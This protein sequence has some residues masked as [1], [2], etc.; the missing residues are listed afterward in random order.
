V[1]LIATDLIPGQK[2]TT[3]SYYDGWAATLKPKGGATYSIATLQEVRDARADVAWVPDEFGD[4]TLNNGYIAVLQ[5]ECASVCVSQFGSKGD[6]TTDDTPPIQ[7]AIDSDASVINFIEDESYLLDPIYVKDNNKELN[8]NRCS[9]ISASPVGLT[10]W[11]LINVIKTASPDLYKRPSQ[12]VPILNVVV[13]NFFIDYSLAPTIA[14]TNFNMIQINLGYNCKITNC[15]LLSNFIDSVDVTRGSAISLRGQCESCVIEYNYV[16]TM[17]NHGINHVNRY[18]TGDFTEA[19]GEFGTATYATQSEFS[20]HLVPASTTYADNRVYNVSKV[21]F[22]VHSYQGISTLK[23]NKVLNCGAFFKNQVGASLA[24]GNYCKNVGGS[25]E[26]GYLFWTGWYNVFSEGAD[27]PD[28]LT[29]VI[30]NEFVNSID[31]FNLSHPTLIHNNDF[32]AEDGFVLDGY[33]G[34]IA[35]Q[36]AR[37]SSITYNRFNEPWLGADST[38]VEG[39]RYLSDPAKDP[40]TTDHLR[41]N[42]NEFNLTITQAGADQARIIDSNHSTGMSITDNVYTERNAATTSFLIFCILARA[43][44]VRV[45]RNTVIR[46]AAQP[47]VLAWSA[48][49]TNNA[50]TVTDNIGIGCS[51]NETPGG[52]EWDINANNLL[53]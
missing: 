40:D 18:V 14:T 34:L 26:I 3:I 48:D 35:N 8:G 9:L 15:L 17:R 50:I 28:V 31:G 52:G 4:L 16:D 24:D 32:L 23:G 53:V 41:I 49:I 27:F 19:A 25:A 21:A 22:D 12:W 2:A 13:D 6:G 46:A 45:A 37:G 7:A 30:N 5:I 51:I 38:D 39:Q 47:C 20:G 42:N 11:A 29:K 44:N 1:D 36:P 43:D 33:R 10:S